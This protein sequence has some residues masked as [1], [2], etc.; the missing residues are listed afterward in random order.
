MKTIRLMFLV[1][2]LNGCV[3]AQ[4]RLAQI[5]AARDARCR[6]F[7]AQPGSDAYVKCRTDIERNAALQ[8]QADAAE[9]AAWAIQW[10]R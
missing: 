2:L 7:G 3:T 9:Y 10:A 5:D 8:A 1:S 4:E 6:S